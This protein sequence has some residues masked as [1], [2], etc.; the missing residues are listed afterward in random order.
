MTLGEELPSV[1]LLVEAQPR[2]DY[3]IDTAWIVLPITSFTIWT[4]LGTIFIAGILGPFSDPVFLLGLLASLGFAFASGT[5]YLVYLLVNR[6]NKHSARE[7][8]LLLV[9]IENLQSKIPG[10]DVKTQIH[11]NSG[12]RDLS[13]LLQED[14]ERSALLWGL[15]S[16]IPYVGPLLIITIL[17]FVS[18]DYKKHAARES[19]VV[20]DIGNAVKV[21]GVHG[22][23]EVEKLRA[24]PDMLETVLLGIAALLFSF[25]Y[26]LFLFYLSGARS[27]L[28]SVPLWL[29][30]VSV[31]SMYSAI[32]FPIPHFSVH[33]TTDN[34][35]LRSMMQ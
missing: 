9:T 19:L 35:I 16:M 14:R 18:G 10:D 24:T 23:P 30:A 25:T 13:T 2:T 4:L 27:V 1:S 22:I 6:R 34:A 7:K 31:V 28:V 33:Q 17:E 20:E 12:E 32:R 21:L 5:A 11:L 26:S 15:L 3:D 8:A 29:S